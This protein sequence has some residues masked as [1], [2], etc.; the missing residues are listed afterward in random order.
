MDQLRNRVRP[1]SGA[2]GLCGW[3]AAALLL[4][5]VGA[6]SAGA[7]SITDVNA[8]DLNTIDGTPMKGLSQGVD[9]TYGEDDL[10][11]YANPNS[12]GIGIADTD[13]GLTLY[14][15]KVLTFETI[16]AD[17]RD[18][19]LQGSGS[20]APFR[21]D[22]TNATAF[23]WEDYH[24]EFWTADFSE[25]LSLRVRN[26]VDGLG[27]FED[28]FE[29]SDPGVLADGVDFYNGALNPGQETRL[30]ISLETVDGSSFVGTSIGVRQIATI[31]PEP[32]TV[33]L[34]GLGL[35]GLTAA[36]RRRLLR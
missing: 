8:G 3:L 31:V 27:G 36:R 18:G 1:P 5:L 32:S 17:R 24:F 22:I 2:C 4:S 13:S 6:A 7:F 35:A 19:F 23:V 20:I 14:F 21:F 30:S 15:D 29:L 9:E 34:L 16:D 11:A 28:A 26:A 12:T 25:R 10:V 33:A